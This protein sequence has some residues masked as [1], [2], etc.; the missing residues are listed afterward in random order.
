[1]YRFCYNETLFHHTPTAVLK[2]ITTYWLIIMAYIGYIW[3][4]EGGGGVIESE[5][6]LITGRNRDFT[7]HKLSANQQNFHEL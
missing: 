7:A 2:T 3:A 5:P 1:M 4:R 6:H